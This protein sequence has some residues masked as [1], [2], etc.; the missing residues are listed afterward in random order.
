M[1]NEQLRQEVA[2]LLSDLYDKKG[3]SKQTQPP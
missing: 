2:R 3:K 1:E